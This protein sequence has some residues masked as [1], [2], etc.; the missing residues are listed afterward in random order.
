MIIKNIKEL[1]NVKNYTLDFT[2]S[3]SE[4]DQFVTRDKLKKPY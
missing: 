3:V 4:L 2:N 1:E